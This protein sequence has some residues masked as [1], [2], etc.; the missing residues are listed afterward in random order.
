MSH[1]EKARC[2]I[3]DLDVLEHTMKQD[4]PD[5]ELV[6]GKTNYNWYGRWVNDYH[7]KNAAY[8]Q[9]VDTKDYG[10]CDH[11]IRFKGQ[12]A[13]EY[14]IGLVKN[15]DGKGYSMVYDFFGSGARYSNKY[16]KQLGAVIQPYAVAMSK[17]KLTSMGY[18]FREE[19]TKEGKVR[20][21][22]L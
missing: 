1:V 17:R 16:G 14:E 19:K 4:N 7:D 3:L 12:D 8:R 2:E 22:T 20:L 10:K 21:I 11:V 6:R 15:A 9:G 13:G 5:L 18:K